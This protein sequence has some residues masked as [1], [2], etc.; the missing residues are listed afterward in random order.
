MTI[1]KLFNKAGLKSKIIAATVFIIVT[2]TIASSGFFYT[3]IK[4]VLFEN[5]RERG[6]TISQNLANSAKYAVLTEDKLVLDELIKGA[7]RSDDVAFITI[8]GSD[9]HTLAE[10]AALKKPDDCKLSKTAMQSL[11][12]SSL[13]HKIPTEHKSIASAAPLSLKKLVSRN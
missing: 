1:R 7:M 8:T 6:S 9:G 11:S 10:K 5:L 12:P 3:R 4:T 2:T 13:S